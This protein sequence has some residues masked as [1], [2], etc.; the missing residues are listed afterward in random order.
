MTDM[1]KMTVDELWKE[2]EMWLDGIEDMLSHRCYRPHSMAGVL[3]IKTAIS[4]HLAWI[5][6]ALLEVEARRL[7]L[8]KEN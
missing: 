5:D 4:G 6:E 3:S 7:R 1:D 2:V 8:A